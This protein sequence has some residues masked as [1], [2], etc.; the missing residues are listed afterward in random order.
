MGDHILSGAVMDPRALTELLPDWREAGAPL[1]TPV[2][3][4]R[5]LF[6]TATRAYRPPGFMLPDCF[7]NHGNHVDSLAMS[8]AG[9]GGKRK[10]WYPNM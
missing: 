4:D 1:N 6:L 9:W 7:R 3:A 8:C 5:V 10:A 2:T